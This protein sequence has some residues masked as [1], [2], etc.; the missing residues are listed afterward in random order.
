[1]VL[2][3]IKDKIRV[4]KI[5]E[6]DAA[7]CLPGHKGKCASIHGHTYKLE[8]TAEGELQQDD[9]SSLDM[10]VDFSDLKEIVNKVIID[11]VDHK[12][13]NE[14]FSFR[15]TAENL[16][17]HFLNLLRKEGEEKG[18]KIAKVKLWETPTSYCEVGY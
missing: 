9:Y 16:A 6:F 3:L 17:L 11:K 1:M 15:T 12:M 4:T 14:V 5:F 2:Y 10:V 7:H 8:I 18:I 13:L